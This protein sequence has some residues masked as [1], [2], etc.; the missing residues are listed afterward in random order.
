MIAKQEVLERAREWNL[1][2]EVVEKDYVL[3]WLLAA[4]SRHPVIRAHWVL[5]GGTCVKKCF[6]ETYRFSEDLDYSLLPSAP[7]DEAA[8]TRTL[9]EL[10]DAT[11][12]LSG[13]R[14]NRD[15]FSVRQ[16]KDKFGR[17]T[18]EGRLGYQGPLA[19]P[20][21]PRIL[22]DIT[23]HEPVL[24]TTA[25]R[26]VLHPYSDG[27]PVGVAVRTYSFVELLAEK[28]RALFERT[29][30]RD[31]YDVAYIL[32]NLE[33]QLDSELVRAT[34]AQKCRLKGFEPPTAAEIVARVH[35][36]EELAAD[37]NDMLSHQLP[38]TAPVE[39]AM[40]RLARSLAWLVVNEPAPIT[41]TSSRLATAPMA[42]GG[43][44]VIVSSQGRGSA[45]VIEQLRFAGANRL[46]VGFTYHGEPRIVEPYSLRW[47]ESTGN[48]NFYAFELDAGIVKCFTVS[49]MS[50]VH[51][52][53]RTF[54]PKYHVELG[55]PGAISHGPWKW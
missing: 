8:I 27:L 50:G 15:Q 24:M 2:P 26:G 20:G 6:F 16:R 48:L 10:A 1:R 7:Y 37:W 29:R 43:G 13:I 14:F 44:Q 53:Q 52:V 55:T 22:F 35:A 34:F 54:T 28:T 49:K 9:H 5:K 19:I 51:V 40:D 45:S 42:A 30:P 36:S 4:A 18:F 33:E 41:G 25:N 11:R 21:W 31:L 46:L 39:G 23:Q 3:G 12:A 32:D 38:Y 47:A 17:P